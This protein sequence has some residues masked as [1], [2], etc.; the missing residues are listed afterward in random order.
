[1]AARIW[2]W[3]TAGESHG[4]GLTIIIDGVP[5]GIPLTEDGIAEDLR[6]RQG[7]YGRGG[8]MLIEKDRAEL[9]AG[10][11]KGFTTGAPVAMWIENR[12]WANWKDKTPPAITVPRPGHADLSGALKFGHRDLR[13][14]GERSSARETTARVAAGAVAKAFLAELGIRVYSHIVAIGDVTAPSYDLEWGELFER[15]EAS[16]VRCADPAATERMKARIDEAKKAGESLGGVFEVAAVGLPP[17]LGSYTQWDRKLD[18]LL[19]QAILSINAI[20]G[21]EFGEGFAVA[22]LPGTQAQ[23][24]IQW[25]PGRPMRTSNRAGGTEGGTTNGE[26]LVLRGAMKPIATTVTRQDSVDLSTGENTK[27]EYQRSDVCAVPA[28]GVVGEAMVALVLAD[29]VL[30]KFGGDNVAETRAALEHFVAARGWLS[31]LAESRS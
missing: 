23:D 30:Q 2:N 12:D 28:A 7:G 25:G 6:R 19:A 4:P 26:P 20:K 16:E 10:V 1:M 29:V 27:M 18:G 9:R 21:V 5:A 15:A 17:G 11:A 22:R 14:V 3:L 24:P 13:I 31:E 8:R